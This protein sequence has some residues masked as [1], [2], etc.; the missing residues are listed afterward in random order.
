MGPFSE[1]PAAPRRWLA[2][3]AVLAAGVL[4]HALW[5]T[6][7][8][9]VVFDEV[10]FG[11]Y[12]LDYLGHRN[13]FDNHPPLGKLIFA[14]MA[15]LL[16]LDPGFGF[17]PNGAPFPDPRYALIR[18]PAHLAGA[19]FPAVLFALALQLGL[20]RWAA[21]VVGLLAALD[22]AILVMSRTAQ[23]DLFLMV[24]GFGALAC[25]LRHR[26]G[27]GAGW[28]AAAAVLAALAPCVKWT[29]LSFTALVL[30]L[31]ALRGW[32]QRDW[33][34][35]GRIAAVL[36]AT[37]LLYVAFFAV[38]FALVEGRVPPDLLDRT[39]AL[40]AQMWASTKGTTPQHAYGSKWYDWPFMMRTV[41]FW[42]RYQDPLMFR[43]YLL[44]NPVVWWA[45]GY[46][47]LYLL[48][49]FLPKLPAL[50]ARERPAPAAP[51]ELLLIGAYLMNML[52][53]TQIRRVTFL[54][55]YL[56]SLGFA[57]LALGLLLDRSGRHARWLG[58][59]LLALAAAAFV[60]WAPLSYGLPLT[61]EQ[62]DA[63]FWVPTWK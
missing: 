5:F 51:V 45:T 21:F 50:V 28:F 12:A 16:G 48:V 11:R 49:N 7:P 33:R 58:W 14:A 8:H 26:N 41:D 63:R 34:S 55:H 1:D 29:G 42:A 52:P 60:Y 35:A 47:M 10:Y 6:E 39:L 54:Y 23:M 17:S 22:N 18:V 15:G 36:A 44:G 25:W 61:R 38:H 19:A 53:F 27:G 57:L 30:L 62:F 40:N 46:A 4:V 13:V 31:E 9:A 43:I 56:P 59:T 3:A 32:R 2:L 37:A 20:S 24:F